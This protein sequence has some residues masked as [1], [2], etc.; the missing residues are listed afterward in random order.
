MKPFFKE[1]M[2]RTVDIKDDVEIGAWTTIDK[3]ADRLKQME[4]KVKKISDSL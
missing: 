1:P 4:E 2:K 3:F